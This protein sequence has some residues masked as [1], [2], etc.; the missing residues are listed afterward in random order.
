MNVRSKKMKGYK[1]AL[2]EVKGGQEQPEFLRE[3]FEQAADEAQASKK[4]AKS[5]VEE[6]IDIEGEQSDSGRVEGEVGRGVDDSGSEV[7][8]AEGANVAGRRGANQQSYAKSGKGGDRSGTGK[9]DKGQK[10]SKPNPYKD[11]L[12]RQDEEKARRE[13]E[14]RAKEQ[15]IAESK[16]RNVEKRKKRKLNSFLATKK[17]KKGQPN[18]NSQIAMLLGKIEK[19]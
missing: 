13:E 2:K 18:M 17:T 8:R 6:E 5:S 19:S 16:K 14:Q 15:D 7:E 10:A 12:R 1:K 9:R 11:I 3:L 4:R